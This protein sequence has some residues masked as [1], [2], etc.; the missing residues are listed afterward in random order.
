MSEAHTRGMNAAHESMMDGKT[1]ASGDIVEE[2]F[3]AYLDESGYV[4]VP[5]VPTKKMI[6]VG[7]DKIDECIDFWNYDSCAGYSVETFAA[8]RTFTEMISAFP[9]PFESNKD[10]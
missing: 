9:S 6:L 10:E 1:G 7:N 2:A 8:N 4:V 3:K 5:K